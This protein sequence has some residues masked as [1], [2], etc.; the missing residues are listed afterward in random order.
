MMATFMA[1]MVPR[2][3]VCA[4]RIQEVL[5]TPTLGGPRPDAGHRAR[6]PRRPRA[7]QRRLPLPRRRRTGAQRHHLVARAGQTTAIVGSTGAGKTTL[8]NLIPRLFDV[9]EGRAAR[10]RRRR[11]RARSGHAVGPH[12]PRAAE[13]VPVLRHGR[14]QPA[15]RASPTPPTTRC[16]RRSR[17][18]RPRDFVSRMPGGLDAPIEQGGTNVSG[19]QRQRLAIARALV[20]KP[21]IYLFDDSFSALDLATDARLRAALAPTVRDATVLIVAQRVSTI[22]NADQ[23]LVLEDGRDGRPR[24]PR[25]AARELSDLRR[26][27][28]LADRRA[29]GRGMSETD[30]EHTSHEGERRG[31]DRPA[32]SETN[33]GVR[34]AVRHR[35]AGGEVEGLRQVRAPPAADD[36]RGGLQRVPRHRSGGRSA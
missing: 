28:R 4:D 29:G 26:D 35:R 33:R 18:P 27:R 25:R 15:L 10:R 16:G 6:R 14:H 34:R 31:R 11:P 21:E 3:A 2:A 5:D 1:V 17:S 30:D 12:R 32:A 36:A 19:G 8:L 20:R 23:I 22:M 7:A 9:T 13:A 24:H